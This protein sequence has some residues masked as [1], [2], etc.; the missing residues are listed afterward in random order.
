MEATEI[1]YFRKQSS[2][3]REGA[4]K[5]KLLRTVGAWKVVGKGLEGEWDWGLYR[6]LTP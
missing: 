6:F 3:P 5:D 4:V 1:K 2:D